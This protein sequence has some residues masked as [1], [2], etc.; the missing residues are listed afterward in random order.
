MFVG[1][2]G[3]GIFVHTSVTIP[4]RIIKPLSPTSNYD[5][6]RVC[7]GVHKPGAYSTTVVLLDTWTTNNKVVCPASGSTHTNS[8]C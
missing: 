2:R 8:V 6:N 5:L 3:G 1:G 7:T 4:R